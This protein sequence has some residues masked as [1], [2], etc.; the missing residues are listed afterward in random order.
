MVYS[1]LLV[2]II[3]VYIWSHFIG[4]IP[5]LDEY[6]VEQVLDVIGKVK[7]SIAEPQVRPERIFDAL[8]VIGEVQTQK[9]KLTPDLCERIYLSGYVRRQKVASIRKK[10]MRG[11]NIGT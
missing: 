9:A 3:G 8:Q 1:S 7:A 10:C 6:N 11:K 5:S 2:A 4:R